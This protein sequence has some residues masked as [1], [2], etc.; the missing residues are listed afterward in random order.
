[1]RP[2]ESDPRYLGL[3][4]A[5]WASI[6]AFSAACYAAMRILKTGKPS[7]P[8]TRTSGEAQRALRTM[9]KDE[10]DKQA[11]EKAAKLPIA[12][13][14]TKPEAK[15]EP[16]AEPKAEVPGDEEDDVPEDDIPEPPKQSKAKTTGKKKG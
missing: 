5:Q 4:F 6:L 13:V 3:T 10:A 7:E 16:K 12:K 2:E 9:L 11:D 1:L 15:P 8:V 14:E